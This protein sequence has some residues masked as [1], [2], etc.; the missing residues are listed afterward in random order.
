LSDGERLDESLPLTL[1]PPRRRRES[2]ELSP[3]WR[4]AV[5]PLGQARAGVGASPLATTMCRARSSD[6]GGNR[7]TR[8]CRSCP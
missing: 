6:S 2:K 3:M 4:Q 7:L 5:S 1:L 8:R